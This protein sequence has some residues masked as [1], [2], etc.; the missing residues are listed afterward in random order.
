MYNIKIQQECSE[1][2]YVAIIAV[3]NK[4]LDTEAEETKLIVTRFRR[5]K[6]NTPEWATIGQQE[7]LRNKF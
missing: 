4:L 3:M 5:T 2:E 7:R 1:E 6:E